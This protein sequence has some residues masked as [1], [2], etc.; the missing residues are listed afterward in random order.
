MGLIGCGARG[1]EHLRAALS[2]GKYE[3]EALSDPNAERL[4][5][6]A[7]EFHPRSTFQ[8]Y[9]EM[10]STNNNIDVVHICTQ[11]TLRSS[12][13]RAAVG[14]GA[15]AIV[16]EKP[17]ALSYSEA[18]AMVALCAEAGVLLVV[19]YQKRGMAEWVA[20]KNAITSGKLGKVSMLRTCCYGNL[21]AQ[22]PHILDMAWN[23]LGEPA[24]RWV[25]GACDKRIGMPE[26]H[27]APRNS[28]AL[29]EF[30]TGVRALF[31]MGEDTPHYPNST[32]EWFYFNM[33]VLGTEGRAEAVLDQGFRRWDR[34]GNLCDSMEARWCDENQGYAQALLSADIY[35][36]L[37][38]V[39]F[40]HPQR[41]ESA[42]VSMQLAEAIG[43][44][45][46]SGCCIPLPLQGTEDTLLQWSRCSEMAGARL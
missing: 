43:R 29:V 34:N 21:L 11:P 22:G 31:A 26:S 25:L 44:S 39:G 19:N 30:A 1:R 6:L 17:M 14:V 7:A 3:V 9:S 27:P 38:N 4:K 24:P 8:D 35:K 33:E 5:R 2:T 28:L 41:G 42:L 15:K 36:A 23:V 37:N 20:L 13:V 18:S 32:S 10:F 45:A 16:V 46:L 12:A 40:K